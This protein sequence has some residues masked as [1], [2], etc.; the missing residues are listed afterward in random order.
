M[1]TPVADA[2]AEFRPTRTHSAVAYGKLLWFV[3][4]AALLAWA[5]ILRTLQCGS[6][7]GHDWFIDHV[8][9]FRGLGSLVLVIDFVL[10]AAMVWFTAQYD[11]ED[12]KSS[13]SMRK[14]AAMFMA[15]TR[16]VRRKSTPHRHKHRFSFWMFV[17]LMVAFTYLVLFSHFL[18]W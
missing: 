9:S 3:V 11:P 14:P 4:I 12:G 13:L 10:L 6:H 18:F 7:T 2:G 17:L 5:L 8:C 15:S 16:A 1:S